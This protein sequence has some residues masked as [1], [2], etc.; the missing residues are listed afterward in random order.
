[1]HSQR[2]D[3]RQVVRV[4]SHRRRRIPIYTYA[5]N[6]QD[7]LA[8]MLSSSSSSNFWYLLSYFPRFVFR[9]FSFASHPY[10]TCVSSRSHQRRLKCMH[11]L[12]ARLSFKLCFTS[13]KKQ[14]K[15]I[16]LRIFGFPGWLTTTAVGLCVCSRAIA[17][18]SATR[19][20]GLDQLLDARVQKFATFAHRHTHAW[21]WHTT[22]GECISPF[23]LLSFLTRYRSAVNALKFG[24]RMSVI[25]FRQNCT[26]FSFFFFFRLLFL[27]CL[28]HM[29]FE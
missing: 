20:T 29:G 26:F 3:Q 16:Y 15:K 1:M 8:H 23:R 18:A 7:T 4:H 13:G 12:L 17:Y 10:L 6:R 14:R 27:G 9:Q 5:G 19:R 2:C 25:S 28:S 21:H 22:N 11:T 24:I